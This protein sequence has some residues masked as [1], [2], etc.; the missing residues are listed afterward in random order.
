MIQEDPSQRPTIRQAVERLQEVVNSLSITALRA[1]P[2]TRRKSMSSIASFL[3]LLAY[4][5]RRLM[6]TIQKLHPIPGRSVPFLGAGKLSGNIPAA[7]KTARS[8]NGPLSTAEHPSIPPATSA[9]STGGPDLAPPNSL[10]RADRHQSPPQSPSSPRH[11]A[12]V[13]LPP[14]ATSSIFATGVP[15][16]SSASSSTFPDREPPTSRAL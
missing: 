14:S 5:R 15:L 1:H 13:P 8:S 6:F 7:A 11:A 10:P 2:T 4:W 16:P 9:G 12:G 3:M